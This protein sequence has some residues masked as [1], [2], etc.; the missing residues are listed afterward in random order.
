MI[1]WLSCAFTRS[2]PQHARRPNAQLGLVDERRVT[3]KVAKLKLVEQSLVAILTLPLSFA[4][5]R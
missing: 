4:C 2:Q 3:G 5:R 1:L